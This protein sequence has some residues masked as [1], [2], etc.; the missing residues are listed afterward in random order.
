M[1]IFELLIK[2]FKKKTKNKDVY[3]PMNIDEEFTEPN[4]EECEHLFLPLDSSNE[5]FACKYCGV[6]V[7]KEKL[8]NKNIFE[9]KSF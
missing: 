2:A 9:N 8:K 7:P 5:Y 6:V 1:Y 4:S 3:N